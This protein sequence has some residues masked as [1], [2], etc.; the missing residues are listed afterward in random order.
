MT[1]EPR[2]PRGPRKD[3]SLKELARRMAVAAE[4]AEGCDHILTCPHHDVV[5]Q[6]MA[7][8]MLE[9]T[10]RWRKRYAELLK[11]KMLVMDTA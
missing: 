1:G 11:V 3:M 9:D 8:N 6:T 5:Q 4:I 2:K 10:D 7:F